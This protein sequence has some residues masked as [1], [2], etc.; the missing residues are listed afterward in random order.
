MNFFTSELVPKRISPGT[1]MS[2]PEHLTQHQYMCHVFL[3]HNR[4][5]A[6][7]ISDHNYPRSVAFD[8]I[9]LALEVFPNQFIK[10]DEQTTC[11]L[12]KILTNFEEPKYGLQ[13]TKIE[14]ELNET[15]M[16]LHQS[17]IALLEKNEKIED[18][19]ARS[20]VLTNTSKKFLKL[21]HKTDKRCCKYY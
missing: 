17:M 2:V 13:I 5:G 4:I 18:M 14:K 20:E 11:K 10:G 12:T 3:N 19:V 15:K 1:R 16:I 6:V 9:N 21:A 7:L 8:V